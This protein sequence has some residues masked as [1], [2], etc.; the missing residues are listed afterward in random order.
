[1]LTE[2]HAVL[3]MGAFRLSFKDFTETCL[4]V[5]HC[6]RRLKAT[7]YR[8]ASSAVARVICLFVHFLNVVVVV[9][10]GYITIKAA[11]TGITYI[12]SE[13]L[14]FTFPHSLP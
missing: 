4:L 10:V 12:C 8:A 9:V 13:T 11:K 14:I 5:Q 6:L 7:I 3:R 1:M 2:F